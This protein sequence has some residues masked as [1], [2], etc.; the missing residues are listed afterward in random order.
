MTP[1]QLIRTHN[2]RILM[3]TGT[4][5]LNKFGNILVRGEKLIKDT[6]LFQQISS[7]R[8]MERIT[9]IVIDET[10]S[11]CKHRYSHRIIEHPVDPHVILEA[12]MDCKVIRAYDMYTKKVTTVSEGYP[13]KLLCLGPDCSLLTVDDVGTISNL[14][15]E[16]RAKYFQVQHLFKTKNRGITAMSYDRKLDIVAIIS[17][18]P[19]YIQGVMLR[20]GLPLWRISGQIQG[21]C[22]LPSGLCWDTNGRIY[23]ADTTRVLVVDGQTGKVLQILLETSNA[24]TKTDQKSKETDDRDEETFQPI[25]DVC[26]SPLSPVHTESEL[27]MLHGNIPTDLT[28][29]C[30]KTQDNV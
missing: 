18:F 11:A 26:F 8:I 14:M 4:L 1:I 13:F 6:S 22:I 7:I 10:M 16:E 24:G 28:I 12:C 19:N 30:F 27:V 15:W 5:K 3:S 9:G 20:D 21:Q 23:V 25:F 2:R 17:H 29:S